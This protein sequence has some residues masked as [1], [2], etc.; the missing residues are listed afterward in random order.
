MSLIIFRRFLRF[1]I[2][3]NRDAA[4]Y[5]GVPFCPCCAR[6]DHH[7]SPTLCWKCVAVRMTPN[8]IPSRAVAGA[9]DADWDVVGAL[10]PVARA[11]EQLNVRHGIGAALAPRDDVIK[12]Q[13]PSRAAL[14]APAAV[15]GR[16]GNL[17]ALGDGPGISFANRRLGIWKP[18]PPARRSPGP[19]RLRLPAGRRR[20]ARYGR[21]S[22]R[23]GLKRNACTP[24]R[25]ASCTVRPP[26]SRARH[27]ERSRHPA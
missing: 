2:N 21:W 22:P 24:G 17:G 14:A 6:V 15:P 13:V 11:A 23:G 9:L 18:E 20:P 1:E 5:R 19:G 10:V 25:A 16:D 4:T 3:S 7:P 8:A 12:M 27:L 26:V